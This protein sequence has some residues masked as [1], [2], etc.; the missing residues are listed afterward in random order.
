MPITLYFFNACIFEFN[1]EFVHLKDVTSTKGNE[2]EDFCLNRDLQMGIYEK[3]YEKPSPIQE[4]SIPIALAGL[5][6]NKLN[7]QVLITSLLRNWQRAYWT[8][9]LTDK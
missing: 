9:Q 2:F 5:F 3:G 4:E 8:F 6:M 1:F 7:A